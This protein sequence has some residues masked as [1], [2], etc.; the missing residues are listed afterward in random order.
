[1]YGQMIEKDIKSHLKKAT[2]SRE[3]YPATI[4]KCCPRTSRTPTT[5]ARRETRMDFFNQVRALK[6]K[7]MQATIVCLGYDESYID[8]FCTEPMAFYKL[9]H[10]P[11]LPSSRGIGYMGSVREG[12]IPNALWILDDFY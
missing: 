4:A 2:T 5:L 1:M 10:H 11:P 12:N 7:V 6:E 9:L 3:T 8:E